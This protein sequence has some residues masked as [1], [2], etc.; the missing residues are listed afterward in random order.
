MP[1]PISELKIDDFLAHPV[2]TWADEEDERLV[3]PLEDINEEHDA[4]FILS[5]F[6]LSDGSMIPGF[7]AVWEHDFSLY[8]VAL[9][10]KNNRLFDIPLQLELRSLID[11]EEI[12]EELDKKFIDIF[13]I[14]YEASF[15][16]DKSL[17]GYIEDFLT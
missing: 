1:K 13:P 14:R 16:P 15:R 12:E 2:W 5:N 6:I 17:T 4:L 11:V 9:A 8:S 7:I 10:G 3:E